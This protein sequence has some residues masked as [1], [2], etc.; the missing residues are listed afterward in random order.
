[1]RKSFSPTGKTF[2]TSAE[3]I[4]PARERSSATNLFDKSLRKTLKRRLMTML[5]RTKSPVTTYK[6]LS[7][8]LLKS[9]FALWSDNCYV[10][11][12]KICCRNCYIPLARS[13]LL[14]SSIVVLCLFNSCLFITSPCPF[15]F[16][17][18]RI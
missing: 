17:F 6:R 13:L 2:S 1:M 16:R 12:A 10:R 11:T 14:I 4:F 5:K 8:V 9:L 15:R 7:K 3:T 18:C